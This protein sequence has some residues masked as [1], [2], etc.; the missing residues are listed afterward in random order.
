MKR[1]KYADADPKNTTLFTKKSVRYFLLLQ[2]V[3]IFLYESTPTSKYHKCG[4]HEHRLMRTLYVKT[5]YFLLLQHVTIFLYG[6]NL[7]K[8][9]YKSGVR[10]QTLMR[11]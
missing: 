2:R 7:T 4:I 8:K 11:T 6:S 10:E 9:Y 5:G 1:H 3:K